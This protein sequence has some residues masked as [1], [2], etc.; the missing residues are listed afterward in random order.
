MGIKIKIEMGRRSLNIMFPEYGVNFK[1]FPKEFEVNAR[2]EYEIMNRLYNAGINVPRPIKLI[3]TKGSA[4]IVREYIDGIYFSQAIQEYDPSSLAKILKNLIIQLRKIEEQEV[5]IPE[6]SSLYK[7]VIIKDKD[8]YIIDLERAQ[9]SSKPIITQL[10]GLL[11]KLC[12]NVK[13]RTKLE[14]IMDIEKIK[15]V[16]IRY[17][18][19]R[20]INDVLSLFRI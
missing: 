11:I 2:R 1:I 8:P 3:I 14:Q 5:F 12:S 6:F 17:K 10:L 20:R 18:E 19:K 4:I 13:I 16:S 9:F 7:N 15:E